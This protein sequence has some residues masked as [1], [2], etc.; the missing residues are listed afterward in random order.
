MA[1]VVLGE[2]AK[3]YLQENKKRGLG[4]GITISTWVG[5]SKGHNRWSWRYEGI[6]RFQLEANPKKV[7]MFLSTRG[8]KAYYPASMLKGENA[9]K[10]LTVLTMVKLD[11]TIDIHQLSKTMFEE[12]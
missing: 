4:Q 5:Q 9:K 10:Y 7:F 8:G 6:M 2:N 3:K 1:K 11:P 12:K